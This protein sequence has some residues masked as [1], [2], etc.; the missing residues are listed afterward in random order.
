MLLTYPCHFKT[1]SC[2]IPAST[3]PVSITQ[4]RFVK[5][6]TNTLRF[7]PRF[8]EADWTDGTPTLSAA[9]RQAIDDEIARIRGAGTGAGSLTPVAGGSRRS[10][11]GVGGA[12]VTGVTSEMKGLQVTEKR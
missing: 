5:P 4:V 6:K 7:T 3:I 11:A 8:F 2:S 9:G 12:G 10:S 1:Y